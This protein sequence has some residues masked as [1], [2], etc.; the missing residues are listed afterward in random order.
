MSVAQNTQY[1]GKKIL[2]GK[3]SDL[4]T[5]TWVASKAWDISDFVGT[6]K[7]DTKPQKTTV[8]RIANAGQQSADITG[9]AKFTGS[10]DIDMATSLLL[11]LVSGVIGKGTQTALTAP[12]WVTATVTAVGD[13]VK[14]SS[15]K[16]LVAQKVLGDMKTGATE[17][18][19]TALTDYTDLTIDGSN[20]LNGVIWKLR[21]TLYNSPDHNTGFCTEKFFIIERAGEGCGSS[22]VFDTIAI[23]VELTYFTIE[24]SDGMLYQK[25]SIPWLS[26]KTSRSS[27]ADYHDITVTLEVKPRDQVFKAKDITVRVDGVKYGTVHNFKLPYTRKVTAIDSVEPNE[28]IMK[29]DSPTLTGDITIELDPIE[30]AKVQAST[31]KAVTISFDHGDGE[32]MLATYPSVTFDEPEVQVNGNEPRL[33]MIMLKPTGNATTA[34]GTLNITT[35]TAY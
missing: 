33:L 34:M 14:H 27:D 10:I 28:Q 18:T 30:Y 16:Y 2:L 15:G 21:N 1:R 12:T 11:P 29:I 25:Q 35:A 8:S 26:T 32:K 3:M 19:I 20:A 24:K 6:F 5:T 23:N 4:N 31:T 7:A 17:P 9:S 13:I 22:N